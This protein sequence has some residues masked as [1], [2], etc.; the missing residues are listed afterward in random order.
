MERFL[1]KTSYPGCMHRD[2][3]TL[4]PYRM[5]PLLAFTLL[6]GIAA[7]GYSLSAA[8]L[9]RFGSGF[10]R[11]LAGRESSHAIVL[12]KLSLEELTS[13]DVDTV[14]GASKHAQKTTEAPVSASLYN[15]FDQRYDHPVSGDF[16]YTGPISGD[17]IA[18]DKARQDGRQFLIKVACIF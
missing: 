17:S 15:G 3:L 5:A 18:L 4:T 16:A 10:E 11:N 9:V 13:I 12:K 7:G 14:A 6:L 1:Q 2:R 8:D